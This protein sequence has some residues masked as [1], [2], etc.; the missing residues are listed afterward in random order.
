MRDK[1]KQKARQKKQTQED[2]GMEE[3]RDVLVSLEVRGSLGGG[4]REGADQVSEPRPALVFP[5]QRS[6]AE[7]CHCVPIVSVGEAVTWGCVS[8]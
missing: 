8:C 5:V 1:E 3:G 2:K 6:A 7:S 4:G